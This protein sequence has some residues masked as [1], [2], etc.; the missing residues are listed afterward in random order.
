[1]K[2]NEKIQFARKK[3]GIS[4]NDFAS[5][6]NVNLSLAQDWESGKSVPDSNTLLKISNLLDVPLDFLKDDGVVSGTTS[7]KPVTTTTTTSTKRLTEERFKSI[8]VWLI[9]GA[10]L[11][12][13]SFASS[14]SWLGIFCLPFLVLYGLTIPLCVG[15]INCARNAKGKQDMVNWGVLSV[16]F[17]SLIGGI[18]MLTTPDSCF[19]EK[20]NK[21]PQQQPVVKETTTTTVRVAPVVATTTSTINDAK[22]YKDLSCKYLNKAKKRISGCKKK[23]LKDDITKKLNLCEND[24]INVSNSKNYV[25][26]KEKI[27]NIMAPFNKRRKTR[28]IFISVG[29]SVAVIALTLSIVLPITISNKRERER[30]KSEKYSELKSLVYNYTDNSKDTRIDYLIRDLSYD[31]D[32]KD[33]ET[34]YKNTSNYYSLTLCLNEYAGTSDENKKISGFLNNISSGYKK[35]DQITQDFSKVKNYIGNIDNQSTNNATDTRATQNRQQLKF[36]YTYGNSSG[37]W[38]F[39]GYLKRLNIAALIRN[40]DFYSS[41]SSSYHFYWVNKS[42][43]DHLIHNIPYPTGYDSSASYYFDCVANSAPKGLKFYLKEKTTKQT[44]DIFRINSLSYSTTRSSLD[45]SVYIY[46]FG[47]DLTFSF[48]I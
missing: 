14:F 48:I 36:L 28:V 46:A 26:F 11:S 39:D 22:K 34:E 45:A 2:L 3:T 10:I 7:Q 43:G 29:S 40:A 19:V 6:L 27:N 13:L 35:V 16:I 42:D 5:L 4:I 1:M 8:K 15:A 9:I 33:I 18:I 20:E 23:E 17:L 21:V 32:L 12:P 24:A 30:I 25:S 41:D 31:Y 44:V 37:L 38:N 47:Y